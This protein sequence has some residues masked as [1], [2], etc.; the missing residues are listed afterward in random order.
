MSEKVRGALFNMLGDISG[1]TILDAFAGSG[2]LVYEAV[3]RGARHATAI[4]IDKHS[5]ALIQENVRSLKIEKNVKAIR[6]NATSWSDNN[7]GSR[8]DIVLLDPPYDNPQLKTVAKLLT[9]V[10]VGG[11]AVLS[12]PPHMEFLPPDDYELVAHAPHGDA[13]L[14]VF[15]RLG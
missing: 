12:L 5:Q 6:A 9:H 11:V 14:Y 10:A 8:F 1:L 7:S 13:Q 15:R 4:E 2:A 3:S